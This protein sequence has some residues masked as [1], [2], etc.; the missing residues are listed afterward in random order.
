MCRLSPYSARDARCLAHAP[1]VLKY[2]TDQQIDLRKMEKL[3]SLFF[4]VA[5]TGERPSGAHR[6]AGCVVCARVQPSLA[7]HAAS[8]ATRDCHACR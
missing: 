1:Q 6:S 7:R 2:K 8:T 3:N 5:A 4:A